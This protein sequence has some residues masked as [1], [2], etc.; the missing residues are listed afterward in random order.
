MSRS[1]VV[2][3]LLAAMGVALCGCAATVSGQAGTA[4]ATTPE[5]SPPTA[6]VCTDITYADPSIAFQPSLRDGET[7]EVGDTSWIGGSFDAADVEVS[8]DPGTVDLADR[9]GPTQIACG[10]TRSEASWLEVS[11]AEPGRAVLTLPDGETIH[12]TVR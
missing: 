4:V 5:S 7:L 8:G 3:G 9:T 1:G 2:A 10:E 11:A 12:V 6:S